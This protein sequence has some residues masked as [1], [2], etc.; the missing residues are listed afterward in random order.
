MNTPPGYD[1]GPINDSRL[2]AAINANEDVRAAV[3]QTSRMWEQ[4]PCDQWRVGDVEQA[5]RTVRANAQWSRCGWPSMQRLQLGCVAV[6][7]AARDAGWE[8][9]ET[10]GE[11]SNG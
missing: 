5:F 3:E 2:V 8:R 4:E 1:G 11:V 10:K 6:Y 9:S 7:R